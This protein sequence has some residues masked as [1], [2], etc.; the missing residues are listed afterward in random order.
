M[1]LVLDIEFVEDDLLKKYINSKHNHDFKELRIIKGLDSFNLLRIKLPCFLV[2]Y[3]LK[4]DDTIH[5]H[6]IP[7]LKDEFKKHFLQQ[8]K[9]KLERLWNNQT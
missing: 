8:R 1:N 7:I 3:G 5:L 6:T 2:T 4:I 9:N